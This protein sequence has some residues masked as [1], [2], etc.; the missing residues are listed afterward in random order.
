MRH[1]GSSSL[2]RDQTQAPA[3]V[4]QSLNCWPIKKSLGSFL[5]VFILFSPPGMLDSLLLYHI[6]IC[7]AIH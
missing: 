4:A 3:L 5:T 1:V 2:T 7:P 6:F